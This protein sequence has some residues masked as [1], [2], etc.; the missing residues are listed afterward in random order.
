MQHLHMHSDS[1]VK[2]CEKAR[3][4]NVFPSLSLTLGPVGTTI[5]QKRPI[6]NVVGERSLRQDAVVSSP[7]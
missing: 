5:T 2:K 4:R 7:F 1:D 3:R 6:G